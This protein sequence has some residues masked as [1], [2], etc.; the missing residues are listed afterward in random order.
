MKR[1]ILAAFTI[2]ILIVIIVLDKVNETSKLG[3]I[4]DYVETVNGDG[5]GSIEFIDKVAPKYKLLNRYIDEAAIK[6]NVDPSLLNCIFHVESTHTLDA[7]SKTG[8]YGIGQ[9]N[10]RSWKKFSPD[11]LLTDLQ[12]SINASAEVLSFYKQLAAQDEPTTWPCRYNV[13]GAS[14]TKGT[15]GARCVHYMSKLNS[16]LQSKN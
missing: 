5:T 6:H 11:R 13:G 7:V 3:P 8:D 9:I 15:V 4:K 12:Y 16:C 1:L 14:L 10:I 2:W